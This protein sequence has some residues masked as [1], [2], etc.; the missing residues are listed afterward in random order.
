M[1]ETIELLKF[2]FQNS[3]MG[4]E[5]AFQLLQIIEEG[6]VKKHLLV[7]QEEYFV[8]NQKAEYLLNYFGFEEKELT[9]Y[10]KFRSYWT[11]QFETLTDKSDSH[12]AEMLI[13]G[14]IMGIIDAKKNLNQYKCAE[15]TVIELMEELRK[16][17][18]NNIRI[19]Y[20]LL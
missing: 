4:L 15:Q 5:A 13:I 2:I 10:D 8:I 16:M 1:D 12:I 19:L 11:I 17:E 18:E 6:E 7:E 3:K 9:W 14:S 20:N